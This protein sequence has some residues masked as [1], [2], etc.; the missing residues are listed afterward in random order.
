MCQNFNSINLYHF[1]FKF[2]KK[3][4]KKN[5][6][7]LGEIVLFMLCMGLRELTIIIIILTFIFIFLAE[8]RI[9]R[10]CLSSLKG[11]RTDIPADKYEGCRKSSLDVKL[12][13]Y[14]N[15][16]IP[17]LDIKRFVF[18][19]NTKLYIL[20]ILNYLQKLL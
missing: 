9:T 18:K 14:V 19:I 8:E 6:Y 10:D 13:H 17:E 16:S 20:I 4:K 5:K 7:I 11:F 12:G 1:Y 3:S 2:L 15:N